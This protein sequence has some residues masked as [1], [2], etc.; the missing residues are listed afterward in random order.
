[1]S[2]TLLGSTTLGFRSNTEDMMYGG[3]VGIESVPWAGRY[4]RIQGAVKWAYMGNEING[5]ANA[6]NASGNPISTRIDDTV[7]SQ[8]LDLQLGGMVYFTRSISL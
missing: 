7:D 1:M 8:L 6:L 5:Q 4:G 3:Q 2:H